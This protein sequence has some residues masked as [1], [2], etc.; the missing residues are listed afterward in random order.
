M[1]G[2][3][4]CDKLYCC[5]YEDAFSNYRRKGIFFNRNLVDVIFY[6]EKK[7]FSFQKSLKLYPQ[8][9]TFISF[10]HP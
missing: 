2:V 9:S 3:K 5:Q 4:L 1:V 7:I 8:D 10:M 6:F